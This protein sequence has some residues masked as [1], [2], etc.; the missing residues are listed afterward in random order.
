VGVIEPRLGPDAVAWEVIFPNFEAH[1]KMPLPVD[2]I[3]VPFP[4]FSTYEVVKSADPLATVALYAASVTGPDTDTWLSPLQA[5]P[6]TDTT[7][8]HTATQNRPATWP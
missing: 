2:E 5:A 6:T 8:T 1:E 4:E 7:T 3:L